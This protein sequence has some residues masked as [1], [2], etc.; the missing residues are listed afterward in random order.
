MNILKLTSISISLTY[1]GPP[2]VVVPKSA[3]G[4]LIEPSLDPA[5]IESMDV[6]TRGHLVRQGPIDESH[7]HLS[8]SLAGGA[9]PPKVATPGGLFNL[10]MTTRAIR[11]PGSVS[12]SVTSHPDLL[13]K[14][15]HD[16]R[17]EGIDA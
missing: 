14:F 7:D 10:N 5:M 12:F 17:L 4:R 16:C 8:F 13:V 2:D 15:M 3:R 1:A 9:W 11:A 6:V